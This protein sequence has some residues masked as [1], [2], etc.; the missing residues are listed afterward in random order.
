MSGH[1][2]PSKEYLL[3]ILRALI[4]WEYLYFVGDLDKNLIT[5]P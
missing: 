4:L 1:E 2:T 5:M 3:I